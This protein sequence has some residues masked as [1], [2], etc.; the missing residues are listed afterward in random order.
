MLT[1]RWRV[2]G[3]AEIEVSHQMH[4]AGKVPAVSVTNL[5]QRQFD[6]RCRSVVGLQNGKAGFLCFLIDPNHA[7]PVTQ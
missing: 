5:A 6:R 2:V 4:N 1:L 7:V 3:V